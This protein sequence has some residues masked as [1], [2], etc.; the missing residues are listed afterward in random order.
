MKPVQTHKLGFSPRSKGVNLKSGRCL[1]S[2]ALLA[3]F[4]NTPSALL[5]SNL[6]SPVKEMTYKSHLLALSIHSAFV[7]QLACQQLDIRIFD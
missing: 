7:V 3:V 2:F 6:R 5:L 1:R 4:L